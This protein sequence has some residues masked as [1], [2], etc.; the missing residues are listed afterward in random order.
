MWSVFFIRTIMPYLYGRF[1]RLGQR[2]A[3]TPAYASKMLIVSE[4]LPGEHLGQENN[5]AGVHREMLHYVGDC[6]E[7]SD[8]VALR[9]NALGE[10]TGR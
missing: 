3:R 5:L 6:F 9:R 4:I 10:T 8:I 7:N 1:N 2:C